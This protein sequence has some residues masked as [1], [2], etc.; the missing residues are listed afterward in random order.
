MVIKGACDKGDEQHPKDVK[1]LGHWN[2]VHSKEKYL[3]NNINLKMTVFWDT[4]PHSQGDY[5]DD[6][7]SKHLRNTGMLLPVYLM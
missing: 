7:G 5:P 1:R 3:K 4:A 2:H 6:G